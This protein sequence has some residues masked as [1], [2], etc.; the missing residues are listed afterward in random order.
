MS[1][2]LAEVYRTEWHE[3]SATPR[4]R[5]SAEAALTLGIRTR[6]A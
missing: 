6:A 3:P 1:T 5:S 4:R 2:A